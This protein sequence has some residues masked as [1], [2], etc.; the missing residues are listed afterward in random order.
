MEKNEYTDYYPVDEI[1]YIA[2]IIDRD[3]TIF[4]RMKVNKNT[5]KK[6]FIAIWIYIIIMIVLSLILG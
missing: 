1:G 5:I 4:E 3:M 6:M 2:K